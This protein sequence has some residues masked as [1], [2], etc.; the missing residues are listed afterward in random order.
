MR[1]RVT[2]PEAAANEMSTMIPDVRSRTWTRK[3]EQQNDRRVESSTH[4]PI[5]HIRLAFTIGMRAESITSVLL[6]SP[7]L[8]TSD[9]MRYIVKLRCISMRGG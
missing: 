8:S 1:A 2:R 9:A 3:G 5:V 4:Y 7:R 6:D